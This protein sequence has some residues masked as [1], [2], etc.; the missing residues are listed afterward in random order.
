MF[1]SL[2]FVI[3]VAVVAVFF[4]LENTEAV[5]VHFFGY[6]LDGSIGVFLLA[7]VGIG[8]L[9]G[10]LLTMP[11]LLGRGISIA[12]Q[13]RRIQELEHSPTEKYQQFD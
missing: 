4:A 6:P 8:V 12:R 3:A 5:R 9:M 10:V 11:A 7:A 1:V 13:K 2:I